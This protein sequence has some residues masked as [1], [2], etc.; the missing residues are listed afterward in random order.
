MARITVATDTG[1]PIVASPTGTVSSVASNVTVTTTPATYRLP[2][3]A[4][5]T[6]RRTI[7]PASL[8]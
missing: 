7:R 2:S 5:S 3:S 1:A 4:A 8:L 6:P